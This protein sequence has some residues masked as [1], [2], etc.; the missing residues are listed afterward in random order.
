M[1]LLARLGLLFVLVPVL[2]LMLLIR[3]GEWMGLWPTLALILTTGA[4][5]AAL[6]R[7]EGL[8]VLF[9]F[10]KELVSG[11]L[12]GQALLDGISVLVGGAFLV[13][14]G[15]LTDLAGLALLLPFTRRR[16]QARVR[17]SLE[18]RVREGT[19]RVAFGGPTGFGGFGGF[20]GT[21][22]PG[23]AGSGLDPDKEIKV[24]S[25]PQ[26]PSPPRA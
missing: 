9:Q 23:G 2:E 17:G 25:P 4:A 5:G 14:P 3:L 22:P 20:G 8:R 13:T 10:Q 24:D 7:A 18:R 19:V 16:I 21:A 11:R 6:A 26:P 15:I 12:P 1:S